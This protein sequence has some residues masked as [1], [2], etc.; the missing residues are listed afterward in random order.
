MAVAGKWFSDGDNGGGAIEIA[1][2]LFFLVFPHQK[3][4]VIF[5]LRVR[6]ACLRS[7]A[8]EP[9]HARWLPDNT[10]TLR[11]FAIRLAGGRQKHSARNVPRSGGCP[12][13]RRASSRRPAAAPEARKHLAKWRTVFRPVGA[14]SLFF[15]DPGRRSFLACP[16]LACGWAFGPQSMDSLLITP[17][18]FR[19]GH[20]RLPRP[21]TRLTLRA[22]S[23]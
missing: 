18:R 12:K 5:P 8:N 7:A 13:E 23:S 17:T 20:P 10:F 9:A 22:L 19:Q 15:L 6:P 11:A 3:Q 1:R 14:R 4:Q 2:K 21:P 16:G